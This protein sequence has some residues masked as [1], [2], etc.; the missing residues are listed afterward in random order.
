MFV[1][2][3]RDCR[4]AAEGSDHRA[5]ASL[6]KF[7]GES[8]R[9]PHAVGAQM[10]G[11]PLSTLLRQRNGQEKI[12]IIESNQH[13]TMPDELQ[14]AHQVH[15]Q[16][17]SNHMRKSSRPLKLESLGGQVVESLGPHNTSQQAGELDMQ[18]NK[19]EIFLK[20]P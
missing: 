7:A 16:R 14:Q 13:R 19:K 20:L 1:Y 18:V 5:A 4:E 11:S 8:S 17:P 9:D 3:S 15:G 12:V 6:A 10:A 2:E